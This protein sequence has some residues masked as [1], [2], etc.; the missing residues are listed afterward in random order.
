MSPRVLCIE[1]DPGLRAT[2]RELLEESGFAVD[3]SPTGLAGIERALTLPPD[4]VLA[5]VHLPDIEGPELASR[6]KQERSLARVPFVAVGTGPAEHD[7]AIAAGCD[8]FI[9]QPIA[10][11]RF[12]SEV[13]AFLAGKRELLDERGERENLRTFS[14]GLAAKL[15]QAVAGASD[16]AARLDR[17]DRLRSAFIHNLSHE[18]STPLTPLAGYLRILQSGKLGPLSDQQRKILDS[19]LAAVGRLTRIVDNLSDFASLQA[20][21]AAIL[22]AVVDPDQLAEDV[23]AEQRAAIKEARLHVTVTRGGG[24]PV[25][26]DARKLRQALAN[27]V[28]NAVKFSPHGG[29]VLVEVARAGDR[30]RFSIYDQGPGIRGADAVNV[31]EPFF[32]AS[33]KGDARAPGSGLGLP[34][35]RRIAEA[36]GGQIVLES[37]PRT[38]PAGT[39]RHFTGTKIV[40]EIP[41]RPVEARP[42]PPAQVSG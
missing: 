39:P 3:E 19:V 20:G 32:H 35:A 4:L 8:G 27:V 14:A 23:V 7:V 5:D 41:A 31:F 12:V 17:S 15:E 37:P 2:V 26:A 22:H 24:G 36:H 13:R 30:L 29:E 34:V 42:Q 28:S 25:Q 6:L 9:E 16:A 18:L 10:R 11:D 40:L 33:R 21:Q 1:G 38:Q